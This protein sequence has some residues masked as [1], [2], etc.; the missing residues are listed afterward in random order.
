[1]EGIQQNMTG[2]FSSTTKSCNIHEGTG[3]GVQDTRESSYGVCFNKNG[4]GVYV[5]RW[6]PMTGIQMWFFPHGQVP[7]D[8]YGLP[9][10]ETWEIPVAD[11]PFGSNCDSSSFMDMRIIVNLT[12]CGHWAG[13]PSSYDIYDCPSTCENLVK[14]K[15]SAFSDAYW[16]INSLKVYKKL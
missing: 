9:K 14:N 12:F 5:M 8:I 13:N 11:Y 3:C 4:G 1:M 16:D 15:P 7:K 6:E 10:P 2:I